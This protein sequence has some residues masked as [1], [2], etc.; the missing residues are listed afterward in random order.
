[1]L[2]E[3]HARGSAREGTAKP[4]A[5]SMLN[6]VNKA[7]R[8]SRSPE[9]GTAALT[10]PDVMVSTAV[11]L[12]ATV[13]GA[14]PGW[15]FLSGQPFIYL[16]LMIGLL[17]FGVV[18]AKRSPINAVLA[19]GY[20]AVLGLMVGAFSRA[21]VAYGGNMELI[22]QAVLGT[23]FGALGVIVVSGTPWGRRAGRATQL[24]T[25]VAL[26]Y[27][28]LSLAS[29]GAS[30]FGVGNGWGFYGLGTLGIVL[31]LVGIALAAWSFLVNLSAAQDAISS[32][33]PRNWQWSLGVS[34]ASSIVWLYL[35]I[36]R[37]L[38]ITSR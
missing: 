33:A 30:F 26:G 28:L 31:C 14:I 13:V 21:A 22:A 29:V 17:F 1:M 20:S 6:E 36:L 24:F 27:F 38:S 35:E 4:M 10:F 7:L 19:L 18:L 32:G 5:N 8:E 2:P 34:V 3:T 15:I 25:A 16:G 37:L 23:A 12:A 11:C 9:A